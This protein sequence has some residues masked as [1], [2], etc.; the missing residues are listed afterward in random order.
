MTT[1]VMQ[2]RATLRY[3]AEL[4]TAF[5]WF[6]LDHFDDP[7]S[8]LALVADT[9]GRTDQFHVTWFQ[10]PHERGQASL[11]RAVAVL[12]ARTDKSPPVA[13][14]RMQN[15]V[16]CD[17]SLLHERDGVQMRL[18]VTDIPVTMAADP[19]NRPSWGTV[20]PHYWINDD[21]LR[22]TEVAPCHRLDVRLLAAS[23]IDNVI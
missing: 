3:A 16:G 6:M 2:E 8:G 21:E 13:Y 7:D 10:H 17:F 4:T 18:I 5:E 11:R 12:R 23:I 20:K 1:K 9:S 22:Q 14:D 19:L 15:P